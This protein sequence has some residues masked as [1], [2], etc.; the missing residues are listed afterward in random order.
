MARQA[1]LSAFCCDFPLVCRCVS[2]RAF[3][4]SS[5]SNSINNRVKRSGVAA[6]GRS[7]WAFESVGIMISPTRDLLAHHHL[8]SCQVQVHGF[9]T[10]WERVDFCFFPRQPKDVMPSPI[11]GRQGVFRG[12]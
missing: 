2:F 10:E 3:S 1:A 9:E 8:D 11:G 12:K 7:A 6:W 5:F 4:V